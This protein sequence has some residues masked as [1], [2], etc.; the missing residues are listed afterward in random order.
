MGILFGGKNKEEKQRQAEFDNVF[1]PL[2]AQQTAT[3]AF[4][5]NLAKDTLGQAHATVKEPL[6]FWSKLLAG[7]QAA[8]MEV[9]GPEM[10]SIGGQS[11]STQRQLAEFSPR[12]GRRT[13]MLGALSD[14]EARQ[15]NQLILGL[16]PQAADKIA[17][18]AQLLF[19]TGISELNAGTGA[20]GNALQSLLGSRSLDLQAQG[21]RMNFLSNLLYSAK[22][23]GNNAAAGGGGG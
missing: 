14:E 9:F 10:D 15:I 1:K 18:I 16:K 4:A 20:S 2:I 17:E 23:S 7:D 19:G 5:T 6:D 12:G 3:S 11:A 13:E 21:Q 8:A 22:Q